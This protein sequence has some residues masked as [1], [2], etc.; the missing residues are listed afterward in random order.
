M[1]DLPL[2]GIR[3]VELCTGA[4][5]PTVSKCLGEYGAEVIKIESRKRGDGHRGGTNPARW[6]T[7]PDFVKLNRNKKS[8][9]LNM[10]TP[11]AIRVVKDLVRACDVVVENYALGV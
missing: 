4:A 8:V 10:K 6:N 9:T 5:G 2:A 11:E 7:S 1:S 3:I